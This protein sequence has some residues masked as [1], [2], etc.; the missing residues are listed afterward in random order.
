M[1][2]LVTLRDRFGVVGDLKVNIL[3]FSIEIRD[4]NVVLPLDHTDVF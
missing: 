3:L 4:L 2:F 1:D